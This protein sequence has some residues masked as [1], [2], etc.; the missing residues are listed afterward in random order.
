M[1]DREAIY[2]EQK[3]TVLKMLDTSD[4]VPL[5]SHLHFIPGQIGQI[6]NVLIHRNDSNQL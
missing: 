1:I 2:E 6:I 3:Y 5:F 4:Y